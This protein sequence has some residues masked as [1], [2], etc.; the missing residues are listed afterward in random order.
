MG[1]WSKAESGWHLLALLAPLTRLTFWGVC[2]IEVHSVKLGSFLRKPKVAGTNWLPLASLTRLTF[3]GVC[4]IE[5][6]FGKL[7]N[8]LRKP[9]VAGTYWLPLASLTRLTF[10]GVCAIKVSFEKLGNFLRK[11]K[12]AGTYWLLI[13]RLDASDGFKSGLANVVDH[14]VV[15]RR[16]PPKI[17]PPIRSGRRVNVG[18]RES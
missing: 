2:A 17:R 14:S 15:Q 18:L 9:K 5:V 10:W 3:W 8:F 13:H 11:P 6:H 7:G 16:L 1:T 12:V 4:A